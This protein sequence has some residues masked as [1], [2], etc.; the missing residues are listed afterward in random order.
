MKLADIKLGSQMLGKMSPDGK[1]RR[2]WWRVLAGVVIT[3]A[4]TIF[5]MIPELT[6]LGFLVDPLI[7]DVAILLFGTQLF[8][9]S[10]QIRAFFVSTNAGIGRCVSSFGRREK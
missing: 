6:L 3:V 10:A 4:A 5:I 8:L 7:L 1:W 2:P 9:S